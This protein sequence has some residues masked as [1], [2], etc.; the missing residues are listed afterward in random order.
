MPTW[1][2]AKYI[3]ET[4]A[5]IRNQTYQNWELII[6][7]DGSDDNTK[8]VVSEIKD[9]RIQF[10]EAGRIGI[11]GAIKNI[12]LKKA[13]GEFIAFIDSDD[14]WAPTKLEQQ[15]L[16]LQQ[17]PDAG[18]CLAGGYNFKEP[19][20]P[21]DYFYK[22]KKGIHYGNIFISCFKSEV[23]G[24]TQA[25]FF[26]RQCITTTGGFKEEKSFSDV[27]FIITLSRHFNAVII[28]DP[29]VY[30][31]IHSNN[32]IHS[33]WEKSY[34]EGIELIESNKK[35]LPKLISRNALFSIY[36]N[37]GEK[38]FFYKD[39]KKAL[40]KFLIAFKLKPFRFAAS[41]KMMKAIVYY[42]IK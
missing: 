33:T 7:D 30:R 34:Y 27:D 17:Y 20:Q 26:K 8:N 21:L 5:T 13:Q 41:K 18:F 1:N 2:R 11:G 15:L 24:F 40:Q 10:Y 9:G 29:L 36:I 37:F 4:I 39:Y 31:R 42:L 38:Y 3:G 32:Y 16:A 6:V 19:G 14:L 22:Q 35:E 28:Y 25:L 23:A 12:G